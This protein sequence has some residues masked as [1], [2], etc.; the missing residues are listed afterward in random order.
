AS[1]A[2]LARAVI[3]RAIDQAWLEHLD[4]I[5]HLRHG[6]GLR[7]YG[8]RDPLTEYKREAYRLFTELLALIQ[9]DIV[10]ALA[11]AA[12][13][14]EARSVFERRGIQL[15]GAA[16]EMEKG[17]TATRFSPSSSGAR[18]RVSEG[19]EGE[20]EGETERPVAVPH[21]YAGAETVTAPS[22]P[23]PEVGRNDPCHC[24]SGK[25]YKKCHGS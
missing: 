19:Q 17:N 15:S 1:F 24:G 23:S 6:I 13:A 12:P 5:E 2:D 21:R 11:H 25:K 20:R 4:A 3:L 9:H 8:Q 18:S 10:R 7:G 14:M 16:K 22:S